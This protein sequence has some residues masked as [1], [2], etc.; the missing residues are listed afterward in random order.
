VTRQRKSGPAAPTVLVVDDDP[1][2]RRYLRSC[3]EPLGMQ[4]V[5][6]NDGRQ[7]LELLSEEAPRL[8]LAIVDLVMPEVD[9][10]ELVARLE[11]DPV[12]SALPVLLV[13]GEWDE[14]GQRKGRPVLRKP[15]N[16]S[17]LRLYVREILGGDAGRGG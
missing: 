6:A 16:G 5:E 13:T 12:Y 9:G 7:A 10:L 3:L 1:G 14:V 2:M 17:L 15:F 8:D 4:V 11:A